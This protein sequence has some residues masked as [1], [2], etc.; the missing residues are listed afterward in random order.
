MRM[1]SYD[2][3]WRGD[4]IDEI[5]V[6]NENDDGQYDIEEINRYDENK[7]NNNDHGE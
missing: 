7:N 2:V 5:D 6:C 1:M 4:N 3:M